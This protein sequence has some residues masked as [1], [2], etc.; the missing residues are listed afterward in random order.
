MI[1]LLADAFHLI[2]RTTDVD[3]VEADSGHNIVDPDL[4]YFCR[5]K[6]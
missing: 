5:P 6:K 1:P 3:S 2:R 4:F